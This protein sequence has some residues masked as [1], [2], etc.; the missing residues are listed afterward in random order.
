MMNRRYLWLAALASS[1]SVPAQDV[2]EIENLTSSDLNGTARFVG[3]GG[4][5]SAL[6]ADLSTMSSNPAGMA[7]Y[8]RSDV[9]ATGGFRK[10]MDHGDILGHNATKGSFDQ[11]GFVYAS[12][13]KGLKNLRFFNF[14]FSYHRMKNNNTL[15]GAAGGLGGLSQSL[16][17]LDLSYD[18]VNN[19]YLDLGYEDN[20]W[21]TSPL[22][23]LG[24]D[25]GMLLPITDSENNVTG[26][27]PVEGNN[28]RYQRAQWGGIN[29]YDFNLSANIRDRFYVGAT[30]GL[31]DVNL[32]T[33]FDYAE[34]FDNQQGNYLEQVDKVVEGTGV[35][36][37]AGIIFRPILTSSLRVGLSFS[38]PVF[39]N[40][41]SYTSVYM[42]S[43]INES[44]ENPRYYDQGDALGYNV[45]TPW[46]VNVSLG[47]T[48]GKYL[49]IGAEYEY[50]NYGSAKVKYDDYDNWGW[51]STSTDYALEAEAKRCLNKVHTLRIGAEA[52][53][54][55]NLQLRVGYNHVTAPM[56][57]DASLDWVI[58]SSA[59][60]YAVQTDYLNLGA[61][62]RYTCG[63]GYR[64][65]HFY[66]DAA[67]QYQRQNAE[68]T[69]FYV[70]DEGGR[71]RMVSQS[72]KLNR[73][74][75]NF[76]LG[77]RF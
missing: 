26:Y 73:Q 22:P 34:T 56:K 23:G 43:N 4:A 66:F 8:R 54:P 27:L 28:Y 72:V 25:V 7:L 11:V 38:T 13:L 44:V 39:Y 41:S 6:G 50:A 17:M 57:D 37:K 24:Y 31:Y 76:T 16:E 33:S 53:L 47:G 12:N 61:I 19:G 45:N 9:A 68:F 35:D 32:K 63:L 71:N 36:F 48:V 51:A 10:N 42:Q 29:Q 40:L 58:N 65:K 70:P 75:A 14:A 2:Y 52:Q 55:Y 60:V 5:M 59:M 62:N 69:P 15:F 64:G 49:A 21:L 74:S 46:K 30:V 3:M 20:R 67:Y 18:Y 1:L 77:Y